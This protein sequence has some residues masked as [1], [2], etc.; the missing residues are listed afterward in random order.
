MEHR[1]SIDFFTSLARLNKAEQRQ[2]RETLSKIIA[3]H[4]G[5]GLRPHKI[6]HPSNKVFSYSPNMDIRVIAFRDGDVMT[7]LYT[8]HHNPAYVW[9]ERR[10]FLCV[11]DSMRVVL[12]SEE[13]P[14][15]PTKEKLQPVVARLSQAG[16]LAAHS[17]EIA[18]L[19]TDDD[20]LEFLD[21]LPLAPEQKDLV[22]ER[23]L[24]ASRDHRL[25]PE[26]TVYVI[27]DDTELQH[28]LEYPL[29]LW[30]IF[31]HPK[32]REIV[33]RPVDQSQIITGGPGTGKTVCL[34]QRAARL[35]RLLGD[36]E[37]I[38][39]STFKESLF[40]YIEGMLRKLH[41]DVGKVAVVDVAQLDDVDVDADA[42]NGAVAVPDFPSLGALLAGE[43][44]P[45][46]CLLV[47]GHNV[48]FS[49]DKRRQRVSHLLVDECQDYRDKQLV[50]LGEIAANVPH[51]I[52]LDYTQSIY[53]PC[54]QKSLL[55]PFGQR[56][57]T[58]R[59]DYC[60]RLNHQI[61]KRIKAVVNTV[62]VLASFAT[63]DQYRVQISTAE[64]ELISSLT[65]AIEGAAPMACAYQ[66]QSHLNDLLRVSVTELGNTYAPEEIVVTAFMPDL[67]K[68]ARQSVTFGI[69]SLPE[70][71]RAYYRFIYTLKGQEY[72]AGIVVLDD[73]ISQL[74]NLNQVLFTRK[75]PS[76]FKG[77][78]ENVRRLYNL[79]YVGLSRFRDFLAVLYPAKYSIVL[80]AMFRDVG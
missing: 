9:L 80:D 6:A 77:N 59:L 60:Y 20:V 55:S 22:L 16:E 30:R 40:D 44:K 39:F 57:D 71:L 5:A 48:W 52:A 54:P 35:A 58:I 53:R 78:A 43:A 76:G 24:L 11:G 1:L 31:L 72:K 70:D 67:Y 56:D 69:E 45:E 33:E 13:S 10:R 14:V 62:R 17:H 18:K 3:D 21:K 2:V 41:V 51:T 74:L 73:S 79:L 12:V 28:A 42:T 32:Q 75:I 23:V 61:V 38:L 27:S 50:A 26:L 64:E 37:V 68:Y 19:T 49:R 25:L 8:D 46:G 47:R 36:N 66:D 7:F 65:P 29:D 63:Q 34:V 15:T 4:Q